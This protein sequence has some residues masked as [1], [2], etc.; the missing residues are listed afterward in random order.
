MLELSDYEK[1]IV[2]S[3]EEHGWF[4]VSVFPRAGHP[5]DGPGFTYSVGFPT[6]LKVPDVIVFGLTSETMHKMLWNVFDAV[7]AGKQLHDRARWDTILP[8]YTCETRAV[9]SSQLVIDYF[10][11]AMWFWD[12]QL[13]RDTPFNA[14]QLFWPG[15]Q[16]RLLPWDT[17]SH[18]SVIDAQPRL[19]LPVL[20]A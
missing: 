15:V 17:G 19:D 8:G 18:Q 3:V 6:S 9:H 2:S 4:G 20:D 14:Y 12:S 11:S 13:K 1:R 10:N 5:T 16:D 7:K